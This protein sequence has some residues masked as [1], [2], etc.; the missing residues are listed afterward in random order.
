VSY[1]LSGD[2]ACKLTLTLAEVVH[3][4]RA[5]DVEVG[6]TAHVDAA[7]GKALDFKCQARA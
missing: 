3:D 2:D 6:K 1:F 7:V 5:H 4:R